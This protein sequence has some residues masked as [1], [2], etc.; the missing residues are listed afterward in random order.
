MIP[1]NIPV[2]VGKKV[3]DISIEG[4]IKLVKLATSIIPAAKE[5]L[6]F[7]PQEGIFLEKIAI[8]APK[9]VIMVKNAP[10][11]NIIGIIL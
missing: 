1:K 3:L 10:A 9:D 7:I 8:K 2:A 4:K 11:I 6:K 5:R